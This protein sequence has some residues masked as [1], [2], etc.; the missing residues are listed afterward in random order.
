MFKIEER[1]ELSQIS[2][3]G[4]RALV[5]LGLLIEAPRSLDEI[6]EKLLE[7]NIIEPT[8]SDDILR[9]D[10]NTLK[11][12][13]CEI[14]RADARTNYKFVL[15]AHPFAIKITD[16]EVAL[17]KKAYKKAKE[18]ATIST[19]IEY[20]ELF[21]K[22]AAHAMEQRTKEQLLGISVLR[23]FDIEFIKLLQ[24]SCKKHEALVLDYHKPSAK[25]KDRKCVVAQELVFQND[26]IYLYGWD[27]DA[28]NSV[29]LNIKRILSILS[30]T[31]SDE[32]E[33]KAFCVKFLLKHIDAEEID[34]NEKILESIE[35]GI[36]VTGRYHNEFIAMQR[37][38]S[39]GANAIVLEPQD[40]RANVIQKL[41]EM[42]KNYNDKGSN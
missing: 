11:L 30:H 31:K 17:L 13:G 24:E 18:H 22:L 19:L 21:N 7:C 39:F 35:D 3:T 5:M 40:F 14:S 37:I 36:I 38:L 34:D 16:E 9:I 33:I 10:L 12:M 4:M 28:K 6:R 20:D 26:K 23:S 15:S 41:K 2:L 32:T 8:H 42:R 29:I 25:D 1:S 27:S